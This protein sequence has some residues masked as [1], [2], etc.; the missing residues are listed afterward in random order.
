M[1]Y[2]MRYLYTRTPANLE[3]IEAALHDIDPEFRIQFDPS[4]HESGDLYYGEQVFGEIAFNATGDEVFTE[5]IEELRELI[6]PI[7]D[8]LKPLIQSVLDH[9]NAMVA[10]RVLEAGH[11]NSDILDQLWDW[12]F[13]HHPGVLQVDEEGFYDAERLILPTTHHDE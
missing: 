2:F 9:A 3:Q 12:L 6:E 11:L 4:D 13:D 1:S 7:D 5:D 8:P 10:L